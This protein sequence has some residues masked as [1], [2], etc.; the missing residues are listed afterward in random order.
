VL[1]LLIPGLELLFRYVVAERM[2]TIIL[3]AIVAHTAWH[4]MV[5]RAETLRQFRFEWPMLT[6][7]GMLVAVRW[8][9]AGLIIGFAVWLLALRRSRRVVPAQ[10]PEIEGAHEVLS[11]RTHV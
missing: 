2:G 7:A 3:S 9:T 10:N 11:G 6:A 1:I 4:W 8:M 5:E